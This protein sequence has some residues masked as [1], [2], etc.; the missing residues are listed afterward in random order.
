MR[1]SSVACAAMCL[2]LP[3]GA[4]AYDAFSDTRS[5]ARFA[6]TSDDGLRLVIKG[7][8]RFGLYDLEGEGGFGNDSNTDTATIGTRS[9]FAELDRTRLAFRLE[10]PSPLAFYSQIR[11]TPDGAYVEGAWIDV[12]HAFEGGLAVHAELGLHAP[13]AA[14]DRFT[15]RKSLAERIYWDQPEMHLA[16]EVSAPVGPLKTWLGASIAMMRPLGLTPVNDATNRG[17]TLAVVYNKANSSFSGIEP[18]FGVRGG[19]SVLDDML[20]VEGFGYL[21]NLAR[22]AGTFELANNI[23][24]YTPREQRD[25]LNADTTYWWAGGRL[26]AMVGGAEFRIEA[27][28][29]A[30]SKLERWTA[31]AQ[32]GYRIEPGIS[33]SWLGMVAPRVRLETYRIIDGDR[34]RVEAP[35]KGLTWDWDIVT[36]ALE[37]R[38]YRDIVTLHIEYS[39]IGEITDGDGDSPLAGLSDDS[40]DNDEFTAQFELRF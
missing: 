12:R 1:I 9:P 14:A 31:Y 34:L 23:P 24:Y 30:E 35:N 13:L 33:E 19:V 4:H 28:T 37:T 15:S 26:D 22:E 7:N 6:L 10:T 39:L 20:S 25:A 29:S 17:G 32:A 11:F 38:I 27:I 36:L 18:V 16:A 2:L 21:G 3:V 40:F 8:A 5:K